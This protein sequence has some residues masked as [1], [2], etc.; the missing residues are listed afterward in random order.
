MILLLFFKPLE[1]GRYGNNFG[2]IIF[3]LIIQ[4]SSLG[5]YCKIALMWMPQIPTNEKSTL[6]QVQL[7][8]VRLHT[9]RCHY[10]TV[11]FLQYPYNRHPIA[12]LWGQAMGCLLWVESDLHSATVF[13]VPHVISWKNGPR[14]NS[15]D[16]IFNSMAP[17]RS[18]CN[19]Y[20]FQNSHQAKISRVFALKFPLVE[21]HRTSMMI[22]QHWCS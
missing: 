15:L 2:N 10:N 1:P 9:V 6:L 19:F 18:G 13:A 7:G 20:N 5:T 17:G 16:C 22:L 3:K 21:C 14:Y 12:C 4:Y 11:N 8:S